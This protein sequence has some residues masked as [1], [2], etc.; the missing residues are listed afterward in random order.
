MDYRLKNVLNR[1]QGSSDGK[2]MVHVPK[3]DVIT[4]QVDKDK[5]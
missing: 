2:P 5:L 1:V 3:Q 4:D